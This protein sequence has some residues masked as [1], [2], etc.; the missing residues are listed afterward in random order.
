[1]RTGC[2]NGSRMHSLRSFRSLEL[3]SGCGEIM[4]DAPALDAGGT[5]PCR[6]K[7][8]QPHQGATTM[9]SVPRPGNNVHI[10]LSEK[11][12][13]RALLKVKPT[14]EMPRPGAANK[15]AKK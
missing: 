1:A 8:G 4:A 9:N 14:E 11:D 15:P 12:A 13:L 3:T 2:R 10:P 5:I 6:F 7:S